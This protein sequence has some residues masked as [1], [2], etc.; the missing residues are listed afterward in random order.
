VT[1][2]RGGYARRLFERLGIPWTLH[3]RRA[4]QAWMQ[5]EGGEAWYN[6]LN[7]TL[8][9]QYSW[10][11]NSVGVQNYSYRDEGIDATVKTFYTKGQGYDRILSAFR[12][13][14]PAR[15]TVRIIGETNWG[16]GGALMLEVL[17]WIAKNDW[18]LRYL[19]QKHVSPT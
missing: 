8:R 9:Q 2:T 19:E 7:T 6:P 4:I 5:S 11:Y 15:D 14:A 10:D 12:N 13:N 16:T 3:N 18:V 17:A 1:V